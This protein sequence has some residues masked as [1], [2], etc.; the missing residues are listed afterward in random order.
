MIEVIFLHLK[1]GQDYKWNAFEEYFWWFWCNLITICS[2]LG[3]LLTL[4]NTWIQLN[5]L[6]Y[7]NLENRDTLLH[8]LHTPGGGSE[9]GV[10]GP[11]FWYVIAEVF[12][13]NIS[14][15][16]KSYS[17]GASGGPQSGTVKFSWP[18]G[19]VSLVEQAVLCYVKNVELDIPPHQLWWLIISVR[20]G[21]GHNFCVG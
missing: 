8:E 3:F 4:G 1:P 6:N 13:H 11:I 9:P 2:N 10:T 15:G 21:L 5:T 17:Q 7:L 18:A 20:G 19:V 14:S 16:S 12:L